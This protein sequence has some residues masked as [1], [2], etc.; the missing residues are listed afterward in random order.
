[1]DD[2]Y[3]ELKSELD[4]KWRS[5]GDFMDSNHRRFDREERRSLNPILEGLNKGTQHYTDPELVG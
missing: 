3:D 2:N 4:A 5:L 1:M